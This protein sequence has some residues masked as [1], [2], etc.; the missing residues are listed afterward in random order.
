MQ[1]TRWAIARRSD[2][3]ILSTKNT[4]PARR[5]LDPQELSTNKSGT[6]QLYPTERFAQ[7]QLQRV[8]VPE[9]TLPQEMV[10]VAVQLS[11]NFWGNPLA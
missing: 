6:L 2:G 5:W 11:W 9:G 7:A 1:M 8:R 10:V 4:A 3:H